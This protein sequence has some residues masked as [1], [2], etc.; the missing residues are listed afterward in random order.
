MGDR[1]GRNRNRKTDEPDNVAGS[2]A[3][4]AP[5]P[6]ARRNRGG[7]AASAALFRKFEIVKTLNVTITPV[8]PA[9]Q[10]H[11]RNCLQ[12]ERTDRELATQT[13]GFDANV[14]VDGFVGEKHADLVIIQSSAR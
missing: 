7:A 4:I 11:A 5:S 9:L 13:G 10:L 8:D 6:I 2:S 14:T 12:I 1:K 3:A